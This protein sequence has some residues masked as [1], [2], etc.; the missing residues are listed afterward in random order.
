MLFYSN[1]LGMPNNLNIYHDHS[2]KYPWTL[3]TINITKGFKTRECLLDYLKS[4]GLLDNSIRNALFRSK[5][6]TAADNLTWTQL[7]T[8]EDTLSRVLE[9]SGIYSAEPVDYP[10]TDGLLLY[11]SDRNGKPRALEISIADGF[12]DD[13][14]GFNGVPLVVRLSSPIGE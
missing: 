3:E 9:D 8:S 12:L 11:I 13:P 1:G 5:K 2:K 14:E 10:L 4:E 6:T 7:G